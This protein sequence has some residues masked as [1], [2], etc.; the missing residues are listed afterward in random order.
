MDMT[1]YDELEA[2]IPK[3]SVRTRFAPSPTGYMHVGNLRTALYTWL[4][5]RKAH[6]TFIFRLE[7]TDQT[8]Q[9]EGAT[10]LIYRTMNE[11]GLTHDEGPDVG[12]PVGPYIQTQRRGLYGKYA[13]LL[14]E[15]GHAYYCFCEKAESEEDSGEFDR[16]EDPCRSLSSEEAAAKIAAGAPYVIRQKIP[17]EGSTTFSDAIF[18]DIT[19]ENNTLDDQVLIKRDG[20][21]TYNFANVVDDHLMGI[22]H[23]V[24]G[25]EYLSSSPKYN[26]LYEAFGWEIPVYVHCSPVMRDAQ[27]KMSKRHGDPSY[28]DLRAQGYLTDAI[29]NYVALLGW[30]PRGELAEQEFFSLAQLVDAFDI[31]GISKSP[32]IFDLE[33]LKYFNSAY[34]KDLSAED[35]LAAATPYLQEGIKNSAIDLSLVA[36]LVQ[37]RLDTL[38][39]IPPM[40]DFFD[41]LPAYSNDLYTHK[42]MKTNPEN[43]LEALQLVLPVFQGM[44]IWTYDSIHDALIHLAEENGLKNGRIMWPVRVAVS[45]KPT[46]PGGAVELCQILGKEETLRRL[47]SGIQQLTPQA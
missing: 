17:H 42:K 38:T 32:A 26:L 11:C 14:V 19:V 36:P 29:L 30:S 33:K 12:G 13:Q 45:G 23:V 16:A 15:K 22:T 10:E 20:L 47:E 25:S 24:R 2:R 35:F 8:R 46:T 18:G 34:I 3:G 1:W 41:T 27:H 28:E 6:G 44:D 39:E 40:V 5:A 31:T 21:P 7:D 9:V 43:S 37:T 4:I